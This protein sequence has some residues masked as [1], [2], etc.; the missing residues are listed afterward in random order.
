M[1]CITDT[2]AGATRTGREDF[3]LDKRYTGRPE[4]VVKEGVVRYERGDAGSV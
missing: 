2:A 3:T 4:A 1:V